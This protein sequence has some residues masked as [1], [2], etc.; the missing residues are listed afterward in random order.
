MPKLPGCD[1]GVVVPANT[2]SVYG[3]DRGVVPFSMP[4]LLPEGDKSVPGGLLA[5]AST[6]EAG[7]DGVTLPVMLAVAD[8]ESCVP[9]SLP[10]CDELVTTVPSGDLVPSGPK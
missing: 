10:G 4:V 7:G 9:V 8:G 6:R 5:G 2:I 1:T 3:C